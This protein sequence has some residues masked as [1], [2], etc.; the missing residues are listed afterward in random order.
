MNQVTLECRLIEKE[1]I[2]REQAR[3]D[4][5]W[6]EVECTKESEHPFQFT[7]CAPPG[8]IAYDLQQIFNGSRLILIGHIVGGKNHKMP[9]HI[10][11]E[12]FRVI[13]RP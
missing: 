3:T 2:R 11:I 13:L 6:I 4:G 8:Q 12:S 9:V 10:N 5:L 1:D 7:A